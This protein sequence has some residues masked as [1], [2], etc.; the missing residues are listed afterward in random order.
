MNGLPFSFCLRVCVLLV[1]WCVVVV[2]RL[3]VVVVVCVRV[4]TCG[5]RFLIPLCVCVRVETCGRRFLIPCFHT[6]VYHPLIFAP[7]LPPPICCSCVAGEVYS[8]S[9]DLAEDDF[10]DVREASCFSF[11]YFFVNP[12]PNVKKIVYFTCT[13]SRSG[14][15]LLSFSENFFVMLC[16]DISCCDACFP[17]ADAPLCC[18]CPFHMSSS[19]FPLPS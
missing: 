13:A 2:G 5:R 11:D 16:V 12:N 14:S 4:K 17:L 18:C 19:M 10:G 15:L 7:T 9:P 8:Y 3:T 6:C 1:L